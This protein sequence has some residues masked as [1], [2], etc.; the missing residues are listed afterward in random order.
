L[1]RFVVQK[2]AKSSAVAW[3]RRLEQEQTAFLDAQPEY[4]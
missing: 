3:F 1:S 4:R 2:R